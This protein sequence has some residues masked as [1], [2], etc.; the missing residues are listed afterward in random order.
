MNPEVPGDVI[1]TQIKGMRRRVIS[2]EGDVS[3]HTFYDTPLCLYA[4]V[5]KEVE[6]YIR[7]TGNSPPS[8]PLHTLLKIK[9]AI[10][11]EDNDE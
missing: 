8:L 11:Q 7:D 6:S 1:R 4:W 3:T 10:S 2:N 5:T 9:R